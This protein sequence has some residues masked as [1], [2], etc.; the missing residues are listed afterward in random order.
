[1][2]SKGAIA[3]GINGL[4]GSISLPASNLRA[5]RAMPIQAKNRPQKKFRWTKKIW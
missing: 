1:M 3:T 2:L 4:A 5:D